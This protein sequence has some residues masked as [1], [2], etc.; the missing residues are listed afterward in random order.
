MTYLKIYTT[1]TVH[2]LLLS[3]TLL[4]PTDNHQIETSGQQSSQNCT[5]PTCRIMQRIELYMYMQS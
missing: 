3:N 5:T 4:P 2:N 1:G